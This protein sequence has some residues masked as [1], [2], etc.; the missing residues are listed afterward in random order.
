[1]VTNSP[2]KN[3]TQTTAELNNLQQLI[4]FSQLVF[5]RHVS[6]VYYKNSEEHKLAKA[7]LLIRDNDTYP[8]INTKV[9]LFFLALQH[10]SNDVEE[11]I[12]VNS[13]FREKDPEAIS[14]RIKLN[15]KKKYKKGEN[16]KQISIGCRYI[17]V[18]HIDESKLWELRGF[19]FI[20][21]NCVC[22]YTFK[23]KKQIKVLAHT[24]EEGLKA[25]NHL[26]KIVDPKWKVGTAEEHCYTA[27]GA[28]DMA[29]GDLHGI[30]SKAT[31]IHIGD[32]HGK[33]YTVFI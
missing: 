32:I 16:G 25:V 23:D 26:L 1:M 14:G 17:E 15:P 19:T 24:T 7:A 33:K 2:I 28:K 20:H 10:L 8:A 3:V 22:L 5:N 11:I 29:K 6:D 9:S 27:N 18:P 31:G 21:G 4:A 13:K 30:T 12:A